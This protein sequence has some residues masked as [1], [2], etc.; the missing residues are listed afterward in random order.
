MGCREQPQT[1]DT[2]FILKI[3]LTGA[4]IKISV[5]FSF[6]KFCFRCWAYDQRAVS[7]CISILRMNTFLASLLI[8]LFIAISVDQTRTVIFLSPCPGI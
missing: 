8:Q 5:A 4:Y 1:T 7:V 2:Q 6:F 3:I